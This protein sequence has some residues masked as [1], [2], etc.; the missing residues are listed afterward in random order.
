[1]SANDYDYLFKVLII[2]NSGVGKSCLLLRFADDMFSEN[3][4]STIGVDFKI[5][6]IQQDGKTIKLQIWDTAGQER[7]KTIT[8]SYYRG[9]NGI[10]VVYDITDRESFEQVAHWMSEIDN[11]A[12]PNVCRL[13]VG[14]KADL[15][16][17]RKVSVDEGEA[18]AKQ[19][20]IPFMETSAKES[21]NVEKMFIT[22]TSAMKTMTG[23]GVVA[24][25]ETT[26]KVPLSGGKDVG[27]KGCC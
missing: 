18:L 13:L 19:F 8:K 10:I 26:T 2:G 4:I 1:M 14:N 17:E 24:P 11:H 20:G 12:N 21:S 25:Q 3:Y 6:K 5:R 7:F 22:M 9:S 16:D 27:K 15:V 23:N